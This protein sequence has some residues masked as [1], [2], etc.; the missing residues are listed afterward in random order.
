MTA[1]TRELQDPAAELDDKV[2]TL[3]RVGVFASLGESG[4]RRLASRCSEQR[5]P[6]DFQVFRRG[7]VSDAVYI[8]CEGNVAVIRDQPGR[9]VQLLARLG[10]GEIF[11]ELGVLHDVER[12]ASVKTTKPCRLLRIASTS[13]LRL[14]EEHT[15]ISVRLESLAARRHCSN[16]AKAL[17][18]TRQLLDELS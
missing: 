11:G 10:A 9:P 12:G 1:L 6:K 14:L 16:S 4:L 13:F 5:L 8:L 15:E 17:D 2:E 3:R 18:L 7:D